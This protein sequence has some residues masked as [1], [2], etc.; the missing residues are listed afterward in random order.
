MILYHY[1]S[2]ENWENN[3]KDVGLIPYSMDK[4]DLMNNKKL[5]WYFK[6]KKIPHMGVWLWEDCDDAFLSDLYAYARIGK[7]VKHGLLLKVEVDSKCLLSNKLFSFY[8][9]CAGVDLVHRLYFQTGEY[10]T[11]TLHDNAKFDICLNPIPI[12]RITRIKKISENIEDVQHPEFCIYDRYH[13]PS[14]DNLWE[15]LY[16]KTTF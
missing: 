8:R 12:E 3:I 4:S 14:T 15:R 7:G 2:E 10:P 11:L 16:Y 5:V 9:D 6:K 13:Y 1:T